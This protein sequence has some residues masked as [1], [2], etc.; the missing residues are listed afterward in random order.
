MAERDTGRTDGGATRSR[1][2]R[3]LGHLDR[4]SGGAE[5]E[6]LHTESTTPG[7][8]GVTSIVYRHVPEAAMLTTITYGVSLGGHPAW[9]AGVPELCLAVRST[10]DAW[11]IAVGS[12]AE[13][14]RGRCPFGYGNTID[15]GERIAAGSR[16]DA[17]GC[18]FPAVLSRED[19]LD[20]D[21]GAA[22]P[23]HLTGIYPLH[24]SEREY[25]QEHGLE[26]FWGLD[27]DPYDVTRRP[28]A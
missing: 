25:I 18:F 27:W 26:A 5:P 15:F 24:G 19:A 21:V 22:L 13:Q 17:F 11:P 12:V 4:I 1:A 16:M 23:V 28:A 10:D 7:L 20:I 6:F 14:L 3:F 9:R 2:Q 8:A